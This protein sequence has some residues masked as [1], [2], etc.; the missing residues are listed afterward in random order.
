[1]RK[2]DI[3]LAHL[4][5]LLATEKAASG[6]ST[7]T[8]SWYTG[9]IARYAD[10]LVAQDLEPTLGAFTLEQVRAYIVAL[11]GLRARALHPLQPTENRPLSDATIN[12]Y[13]RALRAFSSWLFEEGY[14]VTPPLARLK[15]PRMTHKTQEVL[16]EAEIASIVCALNPRTEIGARDQAI[17]LLL[18]DTGI[19]AGELCGLRLPQLHVDEGYAVVLGKGRKERP[20]KIGARAAKAVRF[21]LLH[22]RRPALAHEDHVFLT[23]RGVTTGHHALASAG[24]EPLS[25]SA[26]EQLI[27]RIGRQV[28]VER[29]HPHLLRHTFACLYLMR[30]R[31]PF[32]LKSLLGHTTLQMTNHYCEAVQQ[33]DVVRADTTSI[34]DG[35]DT[36]L[37]EINRRGRLAHKRAPRERLAHK[38]APRERLAQ[39]APA[40]TC[41]APAVIGS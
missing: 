40:A 26:L 36:K 35:L 12:S 31:D 9:V 25:V 24:G 32:A 18:L 29:L 30:Y 10:W 38:R 20:I 37:L 28:G 19:R 41:D 6:K 33:M 1:M 5:E 2:D 4:S 14:T 11:Q 22:W 27:K 23:C 8:V 15:A 39:R 3:S 13:V 7:E 17:F 21:Y 16:T 34:V